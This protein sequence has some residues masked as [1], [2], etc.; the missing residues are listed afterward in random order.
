MGVGSYAADLMTMSNLNNTDS[1]AHF[2]YDHYNR[3]TALLAKQ[4]TDI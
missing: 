3:P 4:D 1:A 2:H